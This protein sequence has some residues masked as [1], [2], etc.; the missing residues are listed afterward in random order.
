MPG[1][2]RF[3]PKQ[4]R[5][6]AHIADSEKKRGMSSKE[7]KSIGFATVNKMKSRGKRK[8]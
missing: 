2:G 3:S 1:K 7:A 5:M 6:A 8:S 4:D